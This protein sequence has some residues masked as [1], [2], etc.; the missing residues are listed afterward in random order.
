M[1]YTFQK[2]TFK[3]QWGSH[4]LSFKKSYKRKTLKS[5]ISS[6]V[7][8][9]TLVAIVALC[10]FTFF[11]YRNLAL[12]SETQR[13]GYTAAGFANAIDQFLFWTSMQSDNPDQHIRQLETRLGN[14]LN[15]LNDNVLGVKI[16]APRPLSDEFF[17]VIHVI[18]PPS[19][20]EPPRTLQN[21]FG[22]ITHRNRRNEQVRMPFG[23]LISTDEWGR[24]GNYAWDAV[25]EARMFYDTSSV[26][27]IIPAFAPV[28]NAHGQVM[29]LVVI[30]MDISDTLWGVYMFV[31]IIAIGA[32]IV[33]ITIWIVIRYI[34][35]SSLAFCMRRIVQA[36][37][38]FE[39][40]SRYFTARTEDASS[41]DEIA[42]VYHNFAEMFSSF[43]TLIADITDMSEEHL[44]GFPKRRLNEALYTGGHLALV[45]NINRMVD[46]YVRDT[47]EL[48]SVFSEYGK[49]N[50]EPRVTTYQGEWVWANDELKT[51]RK[52]FI[53]L[54][55]EVSILAENATKGKFD[56][57]ANVTNQQGEWLS[58]IEKLNRLMDSV[59]HP[60]DEVVAGIV[61]FSEG[62]FNI[63]RGEYSGRF[64]E[65]RDAYNNTCRNTRAMVDDISQVIHSISAGDLTVVT[66][67]RYIG[68]YAQISHAFNTILSD[69]NS[70]IKEINNAAHQVMYASNNLIQSASN[71]AE[72]SN[73]QASTV[74][75]LYAS[76]S[77]IEERTNSSAKLANSASDLA[78]KSNEQ[79]QISTE[80]M[81][82]MLDS[83]QSIKQSSDSISYIIKS[84]QDIA[85]QTNML[86]L[87]AAVESARAG[88]YGKGF[89][90]VA[91][92]VGSLAYK[93]QEA[94]KETTEL[95]LDSTGRVDDGTNRVEKA[96][97]S[98][99]KI[100]DSVNQVYES[101]A[102]IAK[103]STE[104]AAAISEVTRGVKLI[105]DV[106]Q[107]ITTTSLECSAIATEF[108]AQ[109]KNL[110]NLVDF[111]KLKD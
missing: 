93:S 31:G 97:N 5:Q 2:Y 73:H 103:I 27:N 79:A 104:Q 51:L 29:G 14:L 58:M 11:M 90:V 99:E 75:E 72:G 85:F 3:E 36:D 70:K 68:S 63:M 107:S 94:V 34:I 32:L 82:Y 1:L 74:Q 19:Y 54:A 7:L 33:I 28:V 10:L 71:L 111:Y 108:N 40:E 89:A 101:I 30:T 86:S 42:I 23:E 52:T 15:E 78:G 64:A 6:M 110:I 87:N 53:D 66:Q 20:E 35:S 43:R 77:L 96:A 91:E 21:M 102:E 12:T 48:L 59:Q 55:S 83:M 45:K 67:R 9:V 95:I 60:L 24:H 46:M 62:D 49:G 44:R 37:H 17:N 69:L 106:V 8:S 92:E 80:H 76:I 105:S 65:V 81:N 38:T 100:V 57:K 50:F 18:R 41:K 13:A 16:I 61:K 56:T 98:L 4:M 47:E 88:Q 109:S 22:L 25:R 39:D 84:I 26:D